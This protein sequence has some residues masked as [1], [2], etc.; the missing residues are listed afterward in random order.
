MEKEQEDA[1]GWD[2]EEDAEEIQAEEE[3]VGEDVLAIAQEEDPNADPK[4]AL[5][6]LIQQSVSANPALPARPTPAANT[7]KA[8]TSTI[9]SPPPVVKEK[10]DPRPGGLF[11]AALKGSTTGGSEDSDSSLSKGMS[12]LDVGSQA[13]K[14]VE[15][16]S[17]TTTKPAEQ[18][19]GSSMPS[20]QSRPK[21]KPTSKPTPPG[22]TPSGSKTKKASP[23]PANKPTSTGSPARQRSDV[24]VR[25]GGG[26]AGM[27]KQI[28]EQ[29][30][31]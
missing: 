22:S 13:S 26:L 12:K 21:P 3:H 23:S 18:V 31:K 7:A 9:A 16:Q 5:R 8:S 28:A 27:M 15:F 6:H 4:Q 1:K 10:K 25:P 20:T 29:N 11:A 19:P 17:K 24:R 2:S 30:S 14:T